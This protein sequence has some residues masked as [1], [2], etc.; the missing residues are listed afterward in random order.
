MPVVYTLFDDLAR[1][2][3]KDP[4]DLSRA[5]GVTPTV[6]AVGGPV[7]EPVLPGTGV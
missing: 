4:R 3:R 2:L 5:K 7:E 1:K 6:A